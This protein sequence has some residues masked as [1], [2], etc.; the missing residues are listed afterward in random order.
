MK[1]D[2]AELDR[3]IKKSIKSDD[4]P[5]DIV[6]RIIEESIVGDDQS[7]EKAIKDIDTP[8]KKVTRIIENSTTSEEPPVEQYNV[9]YACKSCGYGKERPNSRC[10]NCSPEEG[11]GNRKLNELE[12]EIDALE[13]K[14]K[15]T[16]CI[17]LIV[18][19][20]FH[21][22]AD[23]CPCWKFRKELKKAKLKHRYGT[24]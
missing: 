2:N 9:T 3:I 7:L 20:A 16:D 5:E 12:A 21:I 4:T 6:P 18:S 10:P 13:Q 19:K 23:K 14:I 22:H 11:Y 15:N 1:V 24:L 17:Y 8:E